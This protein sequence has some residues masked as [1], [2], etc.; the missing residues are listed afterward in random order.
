M[1]LASE[2]PG[3]LQAAFIPIACHGILK[4]LQKQKRRL[5]PAIPQAQKQRQ[6]C[7]GQKQQRQSLLL[8]KAV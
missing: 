5:L 1:C 7:A 8:Q 4:T 3:L 2:M 6:A